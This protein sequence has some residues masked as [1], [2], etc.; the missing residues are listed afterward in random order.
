MKYKNIHSAIHN[1]GDSFFSLMNYVDNN[2]VID[3]LENIHRNGYDIEIDW[4]NI[5]FTPKE[6][7]TK[8]ILESISYRAS[9]LKDHF[10]SQNVD[11][12]AIKSLYFKWPAKGRKYMEATDDNS[13]KYKIYVQESK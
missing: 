1:F 11:I 8:R 10:K 6:M 13:K 7:V 2:Y 12:G 3:D 4:I 5:S 9:Y